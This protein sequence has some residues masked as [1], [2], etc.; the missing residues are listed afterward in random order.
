M[1]KKESNTKKKPIDKNKGGRPK[2]ELDEKLFGELCALQCTKIEICESLNMTAKTL[3]RLMKEVYDSSFSLIYKQ[4]RASGYTSLRR[5]QFKLSETNP[6]LSIF[7][8]KNYLKQS[9]NGVLDEVDE[10]EIRT[11]PAR[12]ISNIFVKNYHSCNNNTNITINRG[13]TSS[14]K[15][16]SLAQMAMEFLLTGKVGEKEGKEFDIIGDTLPFVKS[17]AMKEFWKY[18]DNYGL[19][20]L[21]H[22]KKTEKQV[23]YKDR[24]L[25]YFSA[26]DEKK[27]KGRRRD[28]VHLPEGDSLTFEIFKQIQMRTNCHTFIDFNPDNEFCYINEE[29]EKKRMIDVGDVEVIQSSYLDNPFLNDKIKGEIELLR[30]SDPE[31]WQ[32]FGLGNY[33]SIAGLIFKNWEPYSEL[34][35][36]EF[37]EF[38]GLDLGHSNSQTAMIRIRW[39]V[40]TANLYLSECFYQLGLGYAA[41]VGNVMENNP[42]NLEVFSDSNESRLVGEMRRGGINI[43]TPKKEVLFGISLVQSFK[44]FVH[45]DSPNLLKEFKYY[46]WVLKSGKRINAPLKFLDHLMDALRYGVTGF[47]GMHGKRYDI[48]ESIIKTARLIS[49]KK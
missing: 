6:A 33:G 27:V 34:P 18:A 11:I 5:S 25:N 35:E 45:E 32:I 42:E 4:K 15:T 21:F 23:L 43:F 40:G 9:D 17:T 47:V 46:K 37:I 36:K 22:H 13:G 49:K 19:T 10:D 38:Y 16:I 20:P 29:L 28:F 39:E 7:L 44:L 3:D 30:K 2:L 8:G 26:D 48:I 24:V 1:T 14:T 31:Y 12:E 41:A